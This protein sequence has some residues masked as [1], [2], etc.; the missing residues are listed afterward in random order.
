M[1]CTRVS[2][3]VLLCNLLSTHTHTQRREPVLTA[4]GM[5]PRDFAGVRPRGVSVCSNTFRGAQLPRSAL[6]ARGRSPQGPSVPP[7]PSPHIGLL[8]G[9]RRSAGA[10]A[11]G[12]HRPA[13][14]ESWRVPGVLRAVAE[15]LCA[16]NFLL[17]NE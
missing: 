14:A 4:T 15:F 9:P 13:A 8:S 17:S 1:P 12:A 16:A 5:S 11:R 2:L 7:E 3:C 6:G 10:A